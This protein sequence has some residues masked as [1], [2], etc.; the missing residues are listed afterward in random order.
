MNKTEYKGNHNCPFSLLCFKV[1]RRAQILL[2]K[3]CEENSACCKVERWV[4]CCIG[5]AFLLLLGTQMK[6]S[7]YT[8]LYF[9]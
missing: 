8:A 5:K 9:Q 2:S 3:P 6:V 7:S 4:S 1:V